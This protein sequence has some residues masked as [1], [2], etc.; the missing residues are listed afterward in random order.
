MKVYFVMI[1]SLRRMR[2]LKRLKKAHWPIFSVLVFFIIWCDDVTEVLEGQSDMKVGVSE[3]V[4]TY[5]N[6]VGVTMGGYD[7]G[8]N[9]S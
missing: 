8:T 4:I 1:E 2:N 5:A 7:A 3:T 9:T 6:P